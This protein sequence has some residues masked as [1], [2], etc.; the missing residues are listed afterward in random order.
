MHVPHMAGCGIGPIGD[1]I[2][3]EIL[4]FPSRWCR[5]SCVALVTVT[6]DHEIEWVIEN[7]IRQE[8]GSY[9]FIAIDKNII[10]ARYPF[11]RNPPEP[12]AAF[13]IGT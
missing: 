12:P 6:I 10:N 9:L 3:M 8:P 5:R 4:L 7:W 13:P 2:L 11:V 1:G